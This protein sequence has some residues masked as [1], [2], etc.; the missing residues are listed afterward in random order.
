MVEQLDTQV[1][2]SSSSPA[3]HECVLPARK[4]SSGVLL[5]KGTAEPFPI[6]VTQPGGPWLTTSHLS[7][8]ALIFPS[9]PLSE[10]QCV[11]L[12]KL[13]LHAQAMCAVSGVCAFAALPVCGWTCSKTPLLDTEESVH[14]QSGLVLV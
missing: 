2:G 12:W 1:L 8:Q 7:K 10:C 13:K 6:A 3:L 14:L 11:V 9:R 4:A 5:F